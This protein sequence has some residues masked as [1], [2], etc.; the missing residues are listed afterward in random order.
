M[1]IASASERRTARGASS[2]RSVGTGTGRS[3][4]ARRRLVCSAGVAAPSRVGEGPLVEERRRAIGQMP[5]ALAVDVD[6]VRLEPVAIDGTQHGIGRADAHLVLRRSAS[7]EDADAQALAHLG[8]LGRPVA[9]EFD[10]VC[11]LDTEPREHLGPDAVAER[12]D[13]GRLGVPVGH[14]EVGVQ[15]ADRGAPDA[16]PL[17]AGG[18]DQ[19]SGMVAGRVAEHAARVLIGERL[20]AIRCGL[21]RRHARS[22]LGWASRRAPGWPTGPPRRC[23]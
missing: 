17:Q 15:L 4:C 11:Q 19:A 9:D 18:V 3:A 8:R 6:Q 5:S 14:D 13:I 2:A 12:A 7:G 20:E 10:L 21:V 16:Q 22:D 23:A 1:S